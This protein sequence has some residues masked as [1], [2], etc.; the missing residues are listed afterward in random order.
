MAAV[1]VV[2]VA[3]VV[4]VVVVVV[5]GGGDIEEALDCSSPGHNGGSLS[6][7]RGAGCRCSSCRSLNKA[8]G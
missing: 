7:R 5:G 2:A 8:A 1:A 6:E 4:V 3:V